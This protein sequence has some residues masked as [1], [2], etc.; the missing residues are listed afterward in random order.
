MVMEA[1]AVKV[2]HA[3]AVAQ[4]EAAKEQERRQWKKASSPAL[5]AMR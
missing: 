1:I 5:E 2:K 3:D 4:E